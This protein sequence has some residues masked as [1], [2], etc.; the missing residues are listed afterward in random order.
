[1]SYSVVLLAA[2][3]GQRFGGNTPKQWTRLGA[4]L[5]LAHSIDRFSQDPR[6]QQIVLVVSRDKV[7]AAKALAGDKAHVVNGGDTREASTAAGLAAVHK[8]C[9]HVL[10]HDAARPL[11]PLAVI[12]RLLDACA[13]GA[14]AVVPVLPV[15]DTLK[16][17]ATGTT[18]DRATLRRAQTPQAFRTVDI[19]ARAQAT[20]GHR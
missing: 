7:D 1:M 18:V 13:H 12:D 17:A 4:K 15:A 3:R 6:C 5:V 16:D 8:D 19:I 14:R 20:N 10:I 9:E 11:I 2:G